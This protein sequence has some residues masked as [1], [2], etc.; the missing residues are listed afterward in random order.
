MEA[1]R[2]DERGR[3]EQGMGCVMMVMVMVSL[4][5]VQSSPVQSS[6][7]RFVCLVELVDGASESV[8]LF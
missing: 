2:E 4:F 3:E 8:L 5:P 1:M 7:I 6:P